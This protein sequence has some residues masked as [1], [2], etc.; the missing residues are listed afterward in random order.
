VVRA[1]PRTSFGTSRVTAPQ[2][3][4]NESTVTSWQATPRSR[5]T[6]DASSREIESVRGRYL[7][8]FDKKTPPPESEVAS[9]DELRL[10]ID[11]LKRALKAM[12]RD[13]DDAIDG[14]YRRRQSDKMREIREEDAAAKPKRL[15]SNQILARAVEKLTDSKDS[16]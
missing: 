5:V 3:K 8:V 14:F 13:L 4:L 2:D 12:S 9:V 11:S 6:K 16:E 7:A 10:E 1:P 15:T